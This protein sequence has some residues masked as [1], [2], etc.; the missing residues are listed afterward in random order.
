MSFLDLFIVYLFVVVFSPLTRLSLLFSFSLS[1][2]SSNIIEWWV[3]IIKS[4]I[5]CM[6]GKSSWSY[7]SFVWKPL[8]VFMHYYTEEF[9]GNLWGNEGSICHI[10]SLVRGWESKVPCHHQQERSNRGNINYFLFIF[11]SFSMRSSIWHGQEMET[12]KKMRGC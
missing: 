9:P 3:N 6:L 8:D 5:P 7:P 10:E 12:N 4:L 2:S 1:S 11:P